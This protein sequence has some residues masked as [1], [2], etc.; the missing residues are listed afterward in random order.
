MLR[1]IVVVLALSLVLSP[2]AVLVHAQGLEGTQ[3]VQIAVRTHTANEANAETD[4]DIYLGY[5]GREINL[6]N[7]DN[8][9]AQNKVDLYRIGGS[10]PTVVNGKDNNPVVGPRLVL[11]DVHKNRVYLRMQDTDTNHWI[12]DEVDVLF[13]A[14][15]G[16]ALARYCFSGRAILGPSTGFLLPLV[17]SPGAVPCS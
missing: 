9:R 11:G 16:Q 2:S 14:F 1:P 6:D 8:D 12:V 3:V 13:Q 7:T 15:Q 17:E 10:N 4:A 5:G